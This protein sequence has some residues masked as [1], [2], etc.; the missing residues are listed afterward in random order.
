MKIYDFIIIGA[1][2]AGLTLALLLSSQY[3]VLLIERESSIGGCHRVQRINNMFTEHSP[4]VYSNSY[5][6]TETI[7]KMLGLSWNQV[8]TPYHF[9][10]LTIGGSTVFNSLQW[11]ELFSFTKSFCLFLLDSKNYGTNIS[12]ANYMNTHSFSEKSQDLIDR[13]CR[14][15]DGAEIKR[16][17]LNQFFSLLNQNFFYSLWQPR[18]P[19]DI[20]L[21]KHWSSCLKN[22]GVTIRLNAAVN[23][24]VCKKN[25]VT[26]KTSQLKNYFSSKIIFAVAPQIFYPLLN[27]H[28]EIYLKNT[29]YLEYI[30]LTFHWSYKVKL[31]EKKIYGFPKNDWG[32][33]FIVLSDYMKFQEKESKTVLSCSVTF[34][35]K[36]SSMLQ[37]TANECSSPNE[38]INEVFRQLSES[39]L[40]YGKLPK[41]TVALLNPNVHYNK[42]KKEWLT[43]DQ[44]FIHSVGTKSLPFEIVPNKI[45]NVGTQNGFHE[46]N[47]TSMESAITNA[48][49]FANQF[50]KVQQVK[51]T[52]IFTLVR[53]LKIFIFV[54]LAIIFVTIILLAIF[55]K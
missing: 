51:L 15:T 32:I 1:G 34:T 29:K 54:T 42:R 12:L 43:I 28:N 27:I 10:M 48:I 4:R 50:E 49:Y 8:F 21:F 11:F 46:Y 18:K 30:A 55:I 52:P 47:F 23:H 36:K 44:T 3:K 39:L 16:Y 38:I 22:M 25:Y 2:P 13:I 7:L 40:E 9:S 14:L 5:K 19:N 45:Y 31:F 17:S 20:G 6:N 24:V 33:S 37:K 41:P 53:F 35:N 26:I